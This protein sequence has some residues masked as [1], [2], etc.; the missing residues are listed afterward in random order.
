MSGKYET[1]ICPECWRH[2]NE[3]ETENRPKNHNAEL[4]KKIENLEIIAKNEYAKIYNKENPYKKA[5]LELK[6]W[7]EDC[8]DDWCDS[9]YEARKD[10]LEKI[11]S[12]EKELLG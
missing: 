6:E 8:L 2:Y 5:F 9:A 10:I 12:L 4:E 7:I 1:K 3:R 11:T